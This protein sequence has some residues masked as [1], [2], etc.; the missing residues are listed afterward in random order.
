[1]KRERIAILLAFIA[2]S[3]AMVGLVAANENQGYSADVEVVESNCLDT[4]E[5]GITEK[6]HTENGLVFEGVMQT[7]NPCYMVNVSSLER[8]GDTY[9]LDLEGNPEEGMCIQCVGAVTY[10]VSFTA[11]ESGE[12]EV[13]HNGEVVDTVEFE[14]DEGSGGGTDGDLFEAISAWFAS[15]F[16]F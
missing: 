1:M 5:T 7:P 16:G 2:I 13:M 9:T 14:V 6:N 11:E 3:A 12:L 4:N 15:I 10:E 8:N